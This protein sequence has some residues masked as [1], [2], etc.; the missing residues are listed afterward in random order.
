MTLLMPNRTVVMKMKPSKEYTIY[1]R[2]RLHAC[3]I[4][5]SV[6]LV[7]NT[8]LF[9]KVLDAVLTNSKHAGTEGT[10]PHL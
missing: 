5:G 1:N 8:C 4:V 3:S 2:K 7:H 9:T 6:L 10:L